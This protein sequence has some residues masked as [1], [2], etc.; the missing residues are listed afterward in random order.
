MNGI[1]RDSRGYDN[2]KTSKTIKCNLCN[3][4]AHGIYKKESKNKVT[5]CLDCAPPFRIVIGFK[6]LNMHLKEKG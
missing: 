6:P 3:N 5:R 2:M 4:P 1:S